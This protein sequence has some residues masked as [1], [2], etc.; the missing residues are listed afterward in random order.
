MSSKLWE[1]TTTD[2]MQRLQSSGSVCKFLHSVDRPELVTI[3][4][5]SSANNQSPQ[6]R[7]LRCQL[8]LPRTKLSGGGAEHARARGGGGTHTCVNVSDDR[9]TFLRIP[10]VPALRVCVSVCARGTAQLVHINMRVN[11]SS[12]R[13]RQDAAG[14]GRTRQDAAGR[15]RTRRIRGGYSPSDADKCAAA[16]GSRRR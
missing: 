13:T 12:G 16:S 5:Q 11:S 1:T 9:V 2:M 8:L 15:G 7:T 3:Q 4:S 10:Q 6:S 14:R